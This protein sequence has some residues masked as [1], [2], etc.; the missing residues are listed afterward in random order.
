L[1]FNKRVKRGIGGI[2]FLILLYIIGNFFIMEMTRHFHPYMSWNLFLAAVPLFFACLV[3]YFLRKGSR[4]LVVVFLVLWLLF[5]PN[6]PYI[7]TDYIHISNEFEILVDKPLDDNPDLKQRVYVFN[8]DFYIW[9]DF[10]IISTGVFLGVAAGL[11][12]LKLLERLA[13]ERLGRGVAFIFVLLVQ[14]L[15]GY[16]ITIGRFERWNS[17]DVFNP[18]NIYEILVTHWDIGSLKFTLLF[19]FMSLTVYM[20]FSIIIWVFDGG[21]YRK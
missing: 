14:L 15:T 13:M 18:M 7:I 1:E 10:V 19:S 2:F 12:S 3:I 17:W 4:F 6:S 21:N 8:D 16:A 20:F 9:V 5:Y 11:M